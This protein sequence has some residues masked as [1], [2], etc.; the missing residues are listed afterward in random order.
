MDS[1]SVAK[2]IERGIPGASAEVTS[3]DNVH[4]Q[5]IVTATAFAGKPV[6]A[7]HRMVYAALGDL[8]GTDIHALSLDTLTPPAPGPAD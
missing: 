6:M 2:L 7:R 1:A 5:A 4:F 3:Q 8:V